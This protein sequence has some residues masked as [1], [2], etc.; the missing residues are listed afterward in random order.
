MKKKI[1][2]QVLE[3]IEPYV[4]KKGSMFES[5]EPS[6]FLLK[7]IDKDIE[8][9]FYFN[10]ES[11]KIDSA[12][13]LLIDWKPFNKQSIENKRIWIHANQL[14]NSFND[15]LNLLKGYE[16]VKT[17]FD[18][19]I[20]KA[21]EDEYYSEFEIVDD[22][23]VD[24]KPFSPKQILQLDEYL[25]TIQNRID[26]FQ[27]N[28]NNAEIECIKSKIEE[29]RNNIT[30]QSRKWVVKQLSNLWAQITKQGPKLMKEFLSEEKKHM[31]KE[32][33]KSLYNFGTDLLN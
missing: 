25:E 10:V 6:N 8:S 3:T 24:V 20:L 17:V 23:E 7:F 4:N 14:E 16:T 12:F 2:L 1:P 19:P 15:W 27:T 13:Q 33:V 22:E 5:I 31:I 28:E 21:F 30:K 32:G 29:L 9:D 18:D 26:E 11:Y